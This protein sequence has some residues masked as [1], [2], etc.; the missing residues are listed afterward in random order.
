MSGVTFHFN[1][2]QTLHMNHTMFTTIA[3]LEYV[4]HIIIHK[5]FTY[6]LMPYF[7]W[8]LLLVVSTFRVECTTF[9]V[10][11]QWLGYNWEGS[12]DR[13]NL[14][15][16][17]NNFI[18]FF[19]CSELNTVDIHNIMSMKILNWY[20]PLYISWGIFTSTYFLTLSDLQKLNKILVPNKIF[21]LV[22]LTSMYFV[23]RQRSYSYFV[24]EWPL[25]ITKKIITS[26][27]RR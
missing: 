7:K 3:R 13:F 1:T 17:K 10:K 15:S 11:L 24:K 14:S 23:H 21:S 8:E 18:T 16:L 25:K 19:Q 20:H 9:F 12:G 27:L 4:C 22:N 2:I 6:C 26:L 5:L